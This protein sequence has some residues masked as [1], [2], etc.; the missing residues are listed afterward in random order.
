MNV[1]FQYDVEIST[2]ID[3]MPIICYKPL[4]LLGVIGHVAIKIYTFHISECSLFH[5]IIYIHPQTP[6]TD[7][8][9]IPTTFSSHITCL[10][11]TSPNLPSSSH[12]RVLRR[13]AFLSPLK[14]AYRLRAPMVCLNE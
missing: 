4:V 5:Y 9:S 1:P 2:G 11:L 12:M 3:L 13:F 7:L 6:W 10:L 8:L 14:R